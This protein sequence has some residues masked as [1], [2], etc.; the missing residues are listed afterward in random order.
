[1]VGGGGEGIDTRGS[2]ALLRAFARSV[3]Q[4]ERS[5]MELT[6]CQRAY[7]R[8]DKHK[9][10]DGGRHPAKASHEGRAVMVTDACLVPYTGAMPRE[11]VRHYASPLSLRVTGATRTDMVM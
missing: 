7:E 4:A 8:S 11:R 1:M 2:D 9:S 5:R 6:V 3:C 10:I